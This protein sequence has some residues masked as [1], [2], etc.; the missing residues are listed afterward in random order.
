VETRS[1][2]RSPITYQSTLYASALPLDDLAQ[3]ILVDEQ[4]RVRAVDTQTGAVRW[5]T[6]ITQRVIGGSP[7]LWRGAIA[8]A[9]VNGLVVL[10]DPATGAVVDG[11]H[12]TVNYLYGAPAVTGDALVVGGQDGLLRALARDE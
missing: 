9:G 7:V 4:G 10:L 11:L 1:V 8:I 3:T 6:Q 12:P 5:T 2:G